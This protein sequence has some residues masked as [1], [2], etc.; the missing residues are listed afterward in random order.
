MLSRY[1]SIII[2]VDIAYNSTCCEYNYTY[3]DI[4]FLTNNFS[5]VKIPHLENASMGSLGIT[6]VLKTINYSMGNCFFTSG[7]LYAGVVC[8][9]MI[10]SSIPISSGLSK[11]LW[12]VDVLPKSHNFHAPSNPRRTFSAF[13]SL[14]NQKRGRM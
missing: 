9:R 11:H 7:A 14:K 8:F 1:A 5:S 3:P 10:S 4:D 2:K 13:R 12:F 6:Q